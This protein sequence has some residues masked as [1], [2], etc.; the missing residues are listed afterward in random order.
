MSP[1]H[2]DTCSICPKQFYV[3]A[4]LGY[5]RTGGI[6]KEYD[7]PLLFVLLNIQP[8]SKLYKRLLNKPYENEVFLREQKTPLKCCKTL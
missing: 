4:D 6:P 3:L 7:L 8:R 1:I 2:Y 5:V